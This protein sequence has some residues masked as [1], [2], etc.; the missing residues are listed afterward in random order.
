MNKST[1][2]FWLAAV[3]SAVV[4]TV[5]AGASTKFTTTWKAPG[6]GGFTLHG[7]KVAVVAISSDQSA[8]MSVEEA[9]AR[10]LTEQGVTAVPAY[11][12]IPVEELKTRRRR[13]RG[14]SGPGSRASSRFAW[15]TSRSRAAWNR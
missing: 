10:A 7:Q 2:R 13:R 1:R 11:R 14:S 12:A 3:L 6:A 15:W 4:F 8:R 9:L 5:S